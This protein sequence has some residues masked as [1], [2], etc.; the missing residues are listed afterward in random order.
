LSFSCLFTAKQ[1]KENTEM[2]LFQRKQCGG[3]KLYNSS[4]QNKYRQVQLHAIQAPPL[5]PPTQI[6][7]EDV[8][9]FIRRNYEQ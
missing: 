1:G 3:S 9:L 6:R 8:V 2:I 5:C 4:F 7:N